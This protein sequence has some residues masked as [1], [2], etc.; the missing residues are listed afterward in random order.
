[1]IRIS[2]R[3]QDLQSV[4]LTIQD[5]ERLNKDVV[6]RAEGNGYEVTEQLLKHAI[7]CSFSEEK[8]IALPERFVS[9]WTPSTHY[10]LFK[11]VLHSHSP[12]NLTTLECRE[13]S[14]VILE[15]FPNASLMYNI[16]RANIRNY[17]T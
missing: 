12:S 17:Q 14:S 2:N 4:L 6:V 7:H 9:H 3:L 13:L 1:M 15:T 5:P 16:K 11:P 8:K 10:G